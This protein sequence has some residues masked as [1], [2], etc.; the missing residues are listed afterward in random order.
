MNKEQAFEKRKIKKH[1]KEC[2]AEGK[3]K[4]QILEDLSLLYKD[5]NTIIRQLE[6]TPSTKTI[7]K[8]RWLNYLLASL[9]LAA[10]ILDIIIISN[11][12][13]GMPPVLVFHYGLC[14][15]LDAIFLV[16]VLLYWIESYSWVASR[17]VVSL[18][19]IAVTAYYQSLNDVHVLI[20][21]SFGLIITFFVLG[22]LLC[23]KLC[24]PRVPK[25]IELEVDESEKINKTKYVFPD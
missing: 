19:L 22:L 9:L 14:V 12:S 8:Y 6:L 5:K 4:Q 18:T 15:A 2:I 11:M 23:V 20:F 24:P 3:P 16:G 17:A 21:I 1:V 13:W 7:H 10:T 25:F